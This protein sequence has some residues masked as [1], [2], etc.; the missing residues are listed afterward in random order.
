MGTV[1]I[2]VDL[3]VSEAPTP[4]P[5]G[6]TTSFTT[7]QVYRPAT[8]SLWLNGVRIEKTSTVTGFVEANGNG[9]IMMTAPQVGDTLW[10]QYEALF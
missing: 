2:N 9:V 3:A 6:T 7:S 4:P 1:T 10:V 8:V 5:N